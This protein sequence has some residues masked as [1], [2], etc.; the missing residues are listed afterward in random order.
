MHTRALPQTGRWEQCLRGGRAT[1]LMRPISC[2]GRRALASSTVWR[3]LGSASIA[4]RGSTLLP[5]S[6]C[7]HDAC[8]QQQICSRKDFIM[9]LRAWYWYSRCTHA[10]S[11]RATRALSRLLHFFRSMFWTASPDRLTREAKNRPYL[12]TKF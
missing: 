1:E 3:I 8:F 4:A 7:P 11:R 6:L 9:A 2:P 5:Q 12:E 10:A